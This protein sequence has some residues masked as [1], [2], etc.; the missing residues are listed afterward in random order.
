M[1]LPLENGAFSFM[2]IAYVPSNFANKTL[3]NVAVAVSPSSPSADISLNCSVPIGDSAVERDLSLLIEPSKIKKGVLRHARVGHYEPKYLEQIQ[4]SDSSPRFS[5]IVL[6]LHSYPLLLG[7]SGLTFSSLILPKEHHEI[8]FHNFGT[9]AN[10]TD[11]EILLDLNNLSERKDVYQERFRVLKDILH[12]PVNY[13]DTRHNW[14][15][16]DVIDASVFV[17]TLPSYAD[18]VP[19]SYSLLSI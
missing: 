17:H 7:P 5:V 15:H 6:S 9:L 13:Q 2:A 16:L 11:I 10:S 8:Q 1:T 3:C 12:Y 18:S 14:T 4:N 19:G